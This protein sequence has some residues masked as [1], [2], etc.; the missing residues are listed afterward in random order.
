M[1][2]LALNRALRFAPTFAGLLCWGL[3]LA[4]AVL[5]PFGAGGN[6]TLVRG[7]LRGWFLLVFGFYGPVGVFLGA[8]EWGLLSWLANPCWL[9][10]T[11]ASMARAYRAA[12]PFG[13]A[14]VAFALTS[15]HL[16]EIPGG[17]MTPHGKIE[18]YEA[19][20]FLWLSSMALCLL[21]PVVLLPLSRRGRADGPGG[22][23][24][25]RAKED[26]NWTA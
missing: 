11:V 22:Q 25:L 23:E 1:P 5:P 26:A 16:R 3:L 4:S 19:G 8:E 21:A 24:R 18:H 2:G 10:A 20:F 13:A 7:D 14:A 15:F 6:G 17:D 9:V 12:I